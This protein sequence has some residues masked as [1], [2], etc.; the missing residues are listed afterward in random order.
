MPTFVCRFGTP[1]G[2]IQTEEREAEDGETL[3]HDLERQGCYVFAITPPSRWPL[4]R[5]GFRT[6][7]SRR[8]T[9]K[10]LLIF[11]QEFHALVR[12]GLPII[13]S[14]D[15]LVERCTNGRLREALTQIR[16]DVKGGLPFSDAT[17][18][19]P[20]LFSHLYVASLRAGEKSGTFVEALERYVTLLKRILTVRQKIVTALTYPAAVVFLS[21]CVLTFL[22]LYVVPTFVQIYSN[23]EA[24]LPVPTQIL[25]QT[26]GL[27]KT[28]AMP[29]FGLLVVSA[30]ALTQWARTPAGR[31]HVDGLLLRLPWIGEVIQQYSASLFCRTLA[32]LLGGGIPIVPSLET[33]ADS[34]ANSAIRERIQ[35]RIPAVSSGSSLAAALEGT[36]AI[37][38]TVLEMI[39]VGES[40]GSLK[41][42][43][44]HVADFFDQ[45]NELRLQSLIT[46]TEI[47]IMGLMGLFV[48]TTVVVMYLPIFHLAGAIH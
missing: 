8:V 45:E 38:P 21:F 43:L 15:L 42:M 14:L 18:R 39:A 20:R 10:D 41:E 35:A 2:T 30:V 11:N 12:A 44:G 36:S 4:L 47:A 6:S 3:R 22:L 48:G 7:L 19:H 46:G 31:R 29:L 24:T 23:L 33:A 40:T 13:Q 17:A 32:A 37:P 26:V 1:T 25:I 27:L 34:L 28:Y 16:N 5:Q 9:L